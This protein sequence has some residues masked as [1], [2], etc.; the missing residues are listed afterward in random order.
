MDY[1]IQFIPAEGGIKKN[2]WKPLILVN[3]VFDHWCK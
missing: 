3:I 2:H 1:M